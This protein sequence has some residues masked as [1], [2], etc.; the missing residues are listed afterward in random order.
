MPAEKIRPG[1]IRTRTDGSLLITCLTGIRIHRRFRDG[2]L[3]LNL[4][5]SRFL[6]M[7]RND[8][9]SSIY[10]K[11]AEGCTKSPSQFLPDP[12]PPA[13]SPDQKSMGVNAAVPRGNQHVSLDY[14]RFLRDI[15]E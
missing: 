7:I 1:Q 10:R 5:R 9:N 14:V 8:K 2:E 13:H 3:G 6:D 11:S 12:T 15:D 4:C